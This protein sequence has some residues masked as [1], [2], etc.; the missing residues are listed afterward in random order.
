MIKRQLRKGSTICI[1]SVLTMFI[2]KAIIGSGTAPI[3]LS[4]TEAIVGAAIPLS[5]T[6]VIKAKELLSVVIRRFGTPAL[7]FLNQPIVFRYR[8]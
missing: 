7:R 2:V 4:L 5:L 8:A 1:L 3:R 6:L